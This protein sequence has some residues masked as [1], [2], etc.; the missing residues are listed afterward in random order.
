M[1]GLRRCEETRMEDYE[2]VVRE[3]REE[4]REMRREFERM[5]RCAEEIVTERKKI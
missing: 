2:R 4:A 1:E 5:N 3:Q